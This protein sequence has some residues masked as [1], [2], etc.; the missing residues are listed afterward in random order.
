LNI[1]WLQVVVAAVMILAV[2]VVQVDTVPH[3]DSLLPLVHLL[4]LLLEGAG[5]A[6]TVAQKT[7]PLE[8][9]LFFHLLLQLAAAAEQGLL[10]QI[11]D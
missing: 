6:E 7:E 1:L 11:Q 8:V 5:L 10:R 9:I 2:E 3:Q 4:Q